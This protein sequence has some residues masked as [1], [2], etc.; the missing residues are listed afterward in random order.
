MR[1]TSS[2]TRENNKIPSEPQSS[3]N[4]QRQPTDPKYS[5]EAQSIKSFHR[6]GDRAFH[7]KKRQQVI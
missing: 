4:P 7:G 5:G 2:D 1:G 3:R 6:M